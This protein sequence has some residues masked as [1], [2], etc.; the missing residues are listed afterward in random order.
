[1]KARLLLVSVLTSVSLLV[2][3]GAAF[4]VDPVVVVATDKPELGPAASE[5]YLAWFVATR[6]GSN[7][8]T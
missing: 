4:A 5:D 1:M 6:H 3:S 7:V 8:C 2:G